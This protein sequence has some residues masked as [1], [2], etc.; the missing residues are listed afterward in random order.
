M[1]TLCEFRWRF[2]VICVI[3]LFFISC[4]QGL[5][6]PG[7]YSF[8][9]ISGVVGTTVTIDGI[10]FDQNAANNI[11][12]FNGT[13]AVVSS[14]TNTNLVTTVPAGATTGS[15]SLTVNGMTATS[16]SAFTVN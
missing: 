6:A 10:G 4:G 12:K 2:A 7:I 3:G 9:P 13:E 1:L 5:E 14:V 15:I 16:P 8:T 11:V